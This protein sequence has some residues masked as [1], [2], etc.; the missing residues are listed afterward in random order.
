MV[1]SDLFVVEFSPQQQKKQAHPQE[2]G[3]NAP[4]EHA[5]HERGIMGHVG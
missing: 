5:D 1:S 2:N 4:E 3:A